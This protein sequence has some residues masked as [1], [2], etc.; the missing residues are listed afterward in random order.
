MSDVHVRI[1]LAKKEFE[2]QGSQ[3]FVES[4]QSVI[5]YLIQ[6]LTNES[7]STTGGRPSGESDAIESVDS[8]ASTD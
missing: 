5:N 2:V 6:G 7:V 3:E 1:C 8:F 4:Y